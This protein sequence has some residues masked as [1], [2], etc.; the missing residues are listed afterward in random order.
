MDEEG[1]W[2]NLTA[3]DGYGLWRLTLVGAEERLDPAV[4]DMPAQIRRAFGGLDIPYKIE[5]MFSWRR[6]QFLADRYV[7]GRVLMAG[8]ACHTTSPTGGHG[9]NTGIGD[10]MD[11]G[12]MLQALVEGWGGPG[13]IAAYELERRPVAPRNF[14]TATKAYQ[15]WVDS[16]G[17]QDLMADTPQGEATRER[18]GRNLKAALAEEWFSRGIA[19]GYRYD[20]S[21]LVIPDGTPP[22]PDEVSTYVQTARPGHRAPHAWLADGRST[23]DLFGDGF[24]M[25]SFAGSEAA[26]APIL[27]AAAARGAPMRL[28]SIDQPEIAALYERDLVLVRPDGHVCWRGQ[29]TPSDPDA[30]VAT[31]TGHDPG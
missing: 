16:E 22:T 8:D 3:I 15:I 20:T 31:I 12:W 18:V 10:V 21:P 24:V 11:L 7:D 23:L 27:S 14:A 4:V 13:L 1:T 6:S 9:C 17:K 29:T 26:A 5:R 30:L 2:A 19:M 28:V 25:L